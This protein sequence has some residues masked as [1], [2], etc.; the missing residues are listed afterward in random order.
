M[1]TGGFRF[2]ADSAPPVRRF[3]ACPCFTALFRAPRSKNTTENHTPPRR[4]KRPP[5]DRAPPV[6]PPPSNTP[7]RRIPASRPPFDRAA[8]FATIER[9]AGFARQSRADSGKPSAP[10]PATVRAVRFRSIASRARFRFAASPPPSPETRRKRPPEA[11]AR[12]GRVR[13]RPA[14]PRPCKPV[15]SRLK[16]VCNRSGKCPANKKRR[17]PYRNA[18]QPIRRPCATVSGVSLKCHCKNHHARRFPISALPPFRVRFPRPC[19]RLFYP[20]RV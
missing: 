11:S 13:A 18:A 10:I 15:S 3:S 17:A 2:L 14:V 9:R 5:F 1:K 12:A 16:T 20:R 4:R 19:R 8:G 7:R 6:S